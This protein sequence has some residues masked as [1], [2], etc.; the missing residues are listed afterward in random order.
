MGL[1]D[2]L[3]NEFVDIIDWTDNTGDTLVWK[4][5]RYQ[6]EI[7]MGAKLTVR[8]SQQA[9]FMNEGKIA[10][11]FQPGMYTLETQ[12]MPILATLKGWRYGFDSPFKADIFFVSTKQFVDQRWGTKNAITLADERFGMIELRAFGTFAFRMEDGGKF[13]KEIAGTNGDFTTDDIN[14]QLRS[15]IVTKFTNAIGSGNIPIEKVAANVEDL[16]N[17]CQEKLNQDFESY[18][19]KIT[20]FLIEN[21]S[22]PDDIKKEIFAYSRLDKI[23]MQKLAQMKAAQSIETAAANPGVGGMGVGMGV[24]VGMGNIMANTMGAAANPQPNTVPPPIP[25]TVQ[26]FV[27]SNGQQT[28]PFDAAN[29]AQMAQFGTLKK[30]SLVWKNGMVGWAQADSVAELT[31]LFNNVPPPLPQ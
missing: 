23:D 27:A 29:L 31:S 22:M 26:F 6:N 5:P 20:K 10:D 11:V 12:N 4:F 24:G 15:L 9:V 19:L 17:L 1:F 28:G 2:K 18:G 8:E 16:S 21:V 3:R 14:G 13:I 25:H 7:K 30:D